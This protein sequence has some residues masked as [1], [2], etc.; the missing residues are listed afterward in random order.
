MTDENNNLMKTTINSIASKLNKGIKRYIEKY[1]EIIYNTLEKKTNNF[2]WQ[3]A[4]I[5]IEYFH[6]IIL[7]LDET[8]FPIWNQL[9]ISKVIYDYIKY[10]NISLFMK[11]RKIL[12]LIIL[13]VYI[14]II[15]ILFLWVLIA[16]FTNKINISVDSIFIKFLSKFLSSIAFTF[17]GITFFLLISLFLCDQE[18]QMSFFDKNTQCRKNNIF[19]LELP[20]TIISIVF[21]IIISF[22]CILIYYT[23]NFIVEKNDLFK[24]SDSY[25]DIIFFLNKIIIIIS[26]LLNQGKSNSNWGIIILIFII[27][28]INTYTVFVYKPY[29]N[30]F[31]LMLHKFSSICLFWITC[32]LIMSI[33]FNN[34]NFDG[35][36]YLFFLG[37]ILLIIYFFYKSKNEEILQFY[38]VDFNYLKSSKERL[39]YIKKYLDLVKNKT[40]DRSSNIIFQSL[41]GNK[42]DNCVNANCKLKHYLELYSQGY[43][44][45]FTLLQ[46]CQ[47]LFET[48]ISK[49]P[50]DVTLKCNFIIFLIVYLNKRKLAHRIFSSINLKKYNI[51]DNYII[52]FCKKCIEKYSKPFSKIEDIQINKNILDSSEYK[53]LFKEFLIKIITASSLYLEFW[54]SL[55]NYYLEGTE[56]FGKLNELAS[57]ITL[58]CEEVEIT[59]KRLHLVKSDD[60]KVINIYSAFL[61]DII[62]D[63]K[64]YNDIKNMISYFSN[65]IKIDERKID[66][67]NFDLKILSDNDKYRYLLVSAHEKNLGNIVDISLNSCQL[68]GYTKSEIIGKSINLLIPEIFHRELNKLIIDYCDKLKNKFYED[69]YLKIEYKPNI[70]E[71]FTHGR[72]KSKYLIPLNL[73]IFLVQTEESDILIVVEFVRKE[74]NIIDNNNF[75]KTTEKNIIEKKNLDEYICILTDTKFIIQSFTPNSIEFLGINSN[76]INSNYNITKYIKEFQEEIYSYSLQ[77]NADYNFELSEIISKSFCSDIYASTVTRRNDDEPQNKIP[78]EKQISFFRNL[79]KNKYEKPQ[80]ITW[81]F[82]EKKLKK[83]SKINNND[84]DSEMNSSKNSKYKINKKFLIEI[85]PCEISDKIIGYKFYFQKL[86]QVTIAKTKKKNNST[87][88]NFNN[89]YLS[90]KYTRYR[91]SV[92][93]SSRK[94][95]CFCLD[96]NPSSQNETQKFTERKLNKFSSATALKLFDFE[97]DNKTNKKTKNIS[98][99][100]K[101]TKEK[102]TLTQKFIPNSECNFVFNI[103]SISYKLENDILLSKNFNDILKEKSIEKIKIYQNKDNKI[104]LNQKK[105][106]SF[107]SSSQSRQLQSSSVSNSGIEYSSSSSNSYNNTNSIN[108][109]YN[110]SKIKNVKPKIRYSDHK[111]KE[112]IHSPFI[113]NK[114]DQYNGLD[115]YKVNNLNKIRL[116]IFD[117]DKEM[118]IDNDKYE[119]R[120]EVENIINN[121]KCRMSSNLDKDINYPSVNINFMQNQQKSDKNINEKIHNFKNNNEKLNDIDLIKDITSSINKKEKESIVKIFLFFSCISIIFLLTLCLLFMFH[122]I[123]RRDATKTNIQ[124]IIYATK[125]RYNLANSVYYVRELTLLNLNYYTKII[126]NYTSP[127]SKNKTEY[128]IKTGKNIQETYQKLHDN[129]G[130]IEQKNFKFSKKST[131]S[132]FQESHIIKIFTNIEISKNISMSLI[133]SFVQISMALSCLCVNPTKIKQNSEDLLN[134]MYNALNEV[135]KCSENLINILILELHYLY[136][137][138][139]KSIISFLPINVLFHIAI[140]FVIIKLYKMSLNKKTTY[141]AIFYGIEYNLIQNSVKKCEKFLNV[142]KR[143]ECMYINNIKNVSE[144]DNYNFSSSY[145]EDKI[146][147]SQQKKRNINTQKTKKNNNKSENADKIQLYKIKVFKIQFILFLILSCIYLSL[148]SYLHYAYIAKANKLADYYYHMQRLHNGIYNLFNCYREFLFD[149]NSIIYNNDSYNSL[150]NFEQELYDDNTI[151][152]SYLNVNHTIIYGLSKK[153][154]E[155]L[156]KD[157]CSFKNNDYLSSDEECDNLMGGVISLGFYNLASF[158]IEEIRIQRNVA[159]SYMYKNLYVGNLTRFSIDNWTNESLGLNKDNKTLFR[160]ELFNQYH[161]HSKMNIL[162]INII[163]PFIDEQ[164]EMITESILNTFVTSSKT[165]AIMF[166]IY[167]IILGILF[168]FYWLPMINEI[169]N[170]ISKTKNMLSIIP[171]QILSEQANI[172]TLLN[173]HETNY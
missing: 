155:L 33:I 69:L 139:L 36:L 61:K 10:I 17:F 42:E 62:N 172:K 90:P 116:M 137:I 160:V 55:L 67:C 86:N 147:D 125:M 56:N 82:F 74:D 71:F 93:T 128:L 21:Q 121:Y 114:I 54:S 6:L 152:I 151:D 19:K 8:F 22:N 77:S 30:K 3:C 112:I 159:K 53:N 68:F 111:V 101:K 83:E 126:G 24:K 168:F 2:Y 7:I 107:S 118:I 59:F 14:S 127:P 97:K 57:D 52:F 64:K 39:Y 16:I 142:I 162:F 63:E 122:I 75:N 41:I 120:S 45:H 11:N 131:F 28:G 113:K 48:S 25:Y 106:L 143:N 29:E 95:S 34:W 171:M 96:N 166:L 133:S 170:T 138:N 49:F 136:S 109:N 9:P 91:G 13:N 50:N 60:F 119:K 89:N 18:N 169:N 110:N 141:L 158:L 23:P 163:L 105:Y 5:I 167:Y 80:I 72:N 43:E 46:Y 51:Q 99:N 26:F 85:L 65:K 104:S 76:L 66:Y 154:N 37:I 58:I 70:L 27:T 165:N 132:L 4:S 103:D 79:I 47:Q 73:K 88:N 153:Y 140:Y 150:I 35:G 98:T 12:Y 144:F 164:K 148:I 145:S 78:L 117:F 15:I 100:K 157:L 38:C 31:L 146:M 134:F 108:S 115:Y 81:R 1:F 130:L 92:S 129:L 44:S 135:G 87:N 32:S 84:S 161:L 20:F 94:V 124:L 102:F 149:N 40:K 123:N 156:N 173:I